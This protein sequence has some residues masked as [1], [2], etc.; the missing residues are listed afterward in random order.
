MSSTYFGLAL[1]LALPSW[2]T[3]MAP[4]SLPQVDFKKMGT[5]G[6]GGS[7][8]GLD[9]WS[10]S[11]PFASTST[12]A[13]TFSSQ[14]D[15]LFVQAS[16]GSYTVLGATNVG[17]SIASI[18]WLSDTLYV[19]GSFSSISGTASANFIS[20][21]PA[22]S[23][24]HPISP[25]LSGQVDTLYCDTRNSEVWVGG[26][27][28]APVGT[29]GNVARWTK[30]SAGWGTVPF[31]GLNG[32]VGSISPS[33]DGFS[34]YFAGDF[35]TTYISNTTTMVNT[36]AMIPFT[37]ST[38]N[39]SNITSISSAPVNT[40]TTGNSGY[41]T[42]FTFPSSSSASGGLNISAEPSTTQSGYSDAKVLL[43]EGEGTW[44]ARDGSVGQVIIQGNSYWTGTGF[45]L[46]NSKVEG[47]ASKTFCIT[48][49]PDNTLINLT[50]TNTTT[51]KNMTCDWECPLSTDPNVAAQ[52][53]LFTE[54]TRNLTGI[55]VFLD[56]WTGDG[57]G[58]SGIQLL[59]NAATSL[60]TGSCSNATSSSAQSVGKW[61]ETTITTDIAATV[62]TV[63]V[64][65]IPTSD[66]VYNSV[67]FYPHVASTAYYDIYLV[68]PGCTQ[69]EDC[70]GR[71]SVDVEVFPQMNGLGWTS[72]VNQQVTDDTKVL[73]Y[74][75]AVDATSSTFG[76]TISMALAA[77]PEQVASGN[78]YIIVADSVDMVLTGVGATSNSTAGSGSESGS[79]TNTAT[80]AT[81]TSMSGGG[82]VT[83]STSTT[84]STAR[85][86]YG[87]YEWVRTSSNVNADAMLSN[88]TETPLTEL[89]FSLEVALNGSGLADW[90]INAIAAIDNIV[91]VG[92]D[93]ASTGNYSN[94]ISF[95]RSTSL[96]TSPSDQGLNGEV[97]SMAV[98]GSDVYLGGSFTAT[99]SGSTAL[100]YLAKYD[101]KADSWTALAGG[102]DGPV[103]SVSQSLT[104]TSQ[105]IVTGNFTNVLATDGT[106]TRTGGYAVYD[107]SSSAWSTSSVL[108]GNVA[109]AATTSGN[110]YLA[111]R[112][113]GTTNNAANGIALLSSDDNGDT[114]ISS[115]S[116][117]GLTSASSSTTASTR[118]RAEI[119]CKRSWS[120]GWISRLTDTILDRAHLIARATTAPTIPTATST[121]PAVLAGTFWTN[122]SA[123][124]KD[125]LVTIFGGNVS[126]SLAIYADNTLSYPSTGIQGVVRAL[127]VVGDVLY[128]GGEGVTQ[129]GVEGLLVYNLAKESWVTGGMASLGASSG[130]T[131]VSVNQIRT[132]TDS[133]TVVVAGNFSTAGSLSCQALCLWDSGSARWDTPG[134][135]LQGGEVRSID[136]AGDSYDIL[137]I[138]GS[139]VAPSGNV[140]YVA[141]YSFGNSTW[142]EIGTS[143]SLPGPALAVA[144]DNKNASNIFAAGYSTS[145]SSPYL[146]QWNGQEWTAQNSSLLTGSLVQQ[147]A[148]VPMSSEH[149]AE[150][151]IEKD[152][153]LM[154]SGDLYLENMGNA[155]SALFDGAQWYPYLVG[156]SSSGTLGAASSLFYSESTFSF[157]VTKFLAR[158][159]IVLVAMAIA[160]GLILLLILLIFLVAYLTRKSEKRYPVTAGAYEKDGGG[161]EVSSIHQNVF[162]NVQAALE[163]S[164]AGGA[165]AGTAVG[166]HSEESEYRDDEY[167]SEEEGRET[168]MRYDFDGPEL[169][170]GEMAMKAGQRIVI[171]DDEQSDE[172]WFARDPA[173]GREG[174]VPATYGR[175]SASDS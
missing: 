168:T 104:S 134:N 118:K 127:E 97:S 146:Q 109:S 113:S 162:N 3:T 75:G 132:R 64:S 7:F 122:S 38:S 45:R 87:V 24:F 102:V 84:N 68:I 125:N 155:T 70:P 160:T 141:T 23:T 167:E 74:S 108:F 98:I 130:S 171:L 58:L 57:P 174:V 165:A 51:G 95:D 103:V 2:A 115:L 90:S 92:G 83:N 100:K 65:T 9:F 59:S 129:G 46:S 147:L 76:I 14:G 44:L 93:F 62:E 131:N 6:L 91:Y 21:T 34:L 8:A 17:G 166:R 148:F 40:S 101:L 41:L 66:P 159:L 55:E 50:Y 157:D 150:G 88:T 35:T 121:S 85:I 133:N 151:A 81:S 111:G 60:N 79:S 11:S 36:T 116:G 4:S 29:G 142:S 73:V 114:T 169:Q 175:L 107:T 123:S 94:I 20:Y 61:K 119:P 117:S 126:N 19:A 149:S 26:S 33:A 158:G 105:L 137:V 37:N 53:F 106:T 112:V 96:A 156:T 39:P 173:T 161:S 110:I 78:N 43:C 16:N 172:W 154:V 15:T 128:I 42:P 144:V 124:A 5:V 86:A 28:D 63:L 140:A 10:S 153:M 52:D 72:T 164:L 54:G 135:G 145:D 139:F 77:S 18:C 49:L 22:D 31:D 138:A 163:Q 89:G 99:T 152:R 143:S 30:Q 170:S 27:F 67:T 1:L 47:R 12:S 56:T 136:F 82:T 13:S 120:E 32:A 48:S 69:M 71:T 80:S 25:G